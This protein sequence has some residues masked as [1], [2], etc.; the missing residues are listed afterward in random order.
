M[1]RNP[2]G[3]AVRERG[4]V[5]IWEGRCSDPD[6]RQL[7]FSVRECCEIHRLLKL[8]TP[9]VICTPQAGGSNQLVRPP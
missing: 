6:F 1:L 9:V 5:D 7:L 8:G 2:W 4:G 3:E